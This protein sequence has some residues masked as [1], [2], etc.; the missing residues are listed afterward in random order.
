M[1]G[2]AMKSKNWFWGIFFLLS[3]VFIIGSQTGFFG[4]IGVLTLVATI[5]LAALIISSIMDRNFFGVFISL[6]FLYMIY[7]QPLHLVAISVWLLFLAAILAGIGFSCIFSVHGF[8]HR[9]WHGKEGMSSFQSTENI[10]DNNPSARL[11]FGSTCKYL[12][13]DNLKS[14][15]FYSSFGEMNL[16]FDQSQVSHEGAEIFMDCSFGSIK[17]YFPR[18]WRVKNNIRVSLGD[19]KEDMRRDQPGADAPQVTLVGNVSFGDIEIHYI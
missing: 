3:A 1:K 13:A 16:Y 15:Q 11:S 4:Q 18:T 9:N 6:A 17:A 12:H 10:D 7:Q 19:V 2:A 8:D 5:L 14:G